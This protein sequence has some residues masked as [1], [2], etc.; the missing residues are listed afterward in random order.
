MNN[1][2]SKTILQVYRYLPRVASAYD[3]MINSRALGSQFSNSLNMAT[4]SATSVA[5]TII[6]LSQRKIT[7]I[8]MKLITENCLKEI[9][10]DLA[11]LLILKYVNGKK[12]VEIAQKMNVCL[13]TFFRKLNS[14]LESFSLSLS[15]LGYNNDRLNDMLKDEKWIL[16]V[17]NHVERAELSLIDNDELK[18]KV[19]SSVVREIKSVGLI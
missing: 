10:R 7:L 14:A 6:D 18:F 3:K 13:R 1:I 9:D 19:E 2:W 4:Q 8:N 17:H 11:K 5:N 16:A 12:S 15:R